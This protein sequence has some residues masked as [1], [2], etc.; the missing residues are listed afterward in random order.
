[1]LG[2]AFT[3]VDD[4]IVDIVGEITNM[5]SGNAKRIYS[6]LGMDFALTLPSIIKGN[7]KPITHSIE[8]DPIV[9]PFSTEAGDFYVELCLN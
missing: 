3:A 2:E 4:T 9:L 1:M 7:E 8:G 5:I 6:E